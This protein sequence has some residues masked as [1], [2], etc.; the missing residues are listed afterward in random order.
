MEEEIVLC[1]DPH[2]LD[3]VEEINKYNDLD[4]EEEIAI[5][6]DAHDKEEDISRCMDA[7]KSVGRPESIENEIVSNL[8]ISFATTI[9]PNWANLNF[10]SL[11]DYVRVVRII[12]PEVIE[13]HPFRA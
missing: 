3:M 4:T 1:F 8:S 5:C 10:F 12:G 6:I 11:T 2:A 13:P 7:V 9:A